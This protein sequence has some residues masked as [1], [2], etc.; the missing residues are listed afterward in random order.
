[1]ENTATLSCK[2]GTTDASIPLGLEIWLDDTVIYNNDH[3]VDSQ[4]LNYEFED[5][6]NEHELQFVMKNKT[7][8]HTQVDENGNIIKDACLTV[9][10][11][12][13]E[14]IELGHMFVEQSVYT[15][16]FNGTQDKVDNKFFGSMGC[17]GTVRLKFTTPIYLWL[18][19]NM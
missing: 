13:F 5:D 1:M 3:V 14:G 9:Q 19:E 11:V 4:Q 8:D 17:N 2:I 18:L 16:D 15:H 12:A 10:D 7:I 6:G